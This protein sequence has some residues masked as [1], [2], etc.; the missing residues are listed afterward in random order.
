[1]LG[2][3]GNEDSLDLAIKQYDEII[4]EN[5]TIRDEI[6]GNDLEKKI[7]HLGQT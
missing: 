6:L 3:D 7:N 1:M 2:T 5:K 4:N